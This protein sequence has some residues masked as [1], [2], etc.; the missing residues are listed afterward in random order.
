M[1]AI[2]VAWSL[3]VVDVRS[4]ATVLG[5]CAAGPVSFRLARA[6]P[7]RER[8]DAA[9]NAA[10]APETTQLDIGPWGRSLRDGQ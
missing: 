6:R 3:I 5:A 9:Q 7:G 4:S 1:K 8:T 10:T 2:A